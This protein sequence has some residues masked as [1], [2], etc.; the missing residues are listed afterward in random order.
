MK[1]NVIGGDSGC[2]MH[3]NTYPLPAGWGCSSC[4]A[5]TDDTEDDDEDDVEVWELGLKLLTEAA[6][7][8]ILFTVGPNRGRLNMFGLCL[9][10]GLRDKI[11]GLSGAWHVSWLWLVRADLSGSCLG[12]ILTSG[13]CMLLISGLLYFSNS[14]ARFPLG[15]ACGAILLSRGS[16]CLVSI[17]GLRTLSVP[18]VG[19]IRW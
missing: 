19:L 14:L 9:I 6:L 17:M 5:F 1:R 18:A 16:S 11:F 8:R 10:C 7:L 12:S 3:G 2:L 15:V 13:P 4:A